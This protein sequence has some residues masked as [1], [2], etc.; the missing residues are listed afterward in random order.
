MQKIQKLKNIIKISNAY[1]IAFWMDE[2]VINLAWLEAT[3]W[4]E[5]DNDIWDLIKELINNN[6]KVELTTNWSTLWKFSKNLIKSGLSKCRISI[7]SFDRNIYKNI[8]GRD[9]LNWVIEGIKDFRE[10]NV[11]III[12]RPLLKGFTDDIPVC[13][14][15]IQKEN[16]TLKLYD[17]WWTKRID[18]IYNNYYIHRSEIIDKYLK[19]KL[20]FVEEKI[21]NFNRNRILYNLVGGGIVD[22][23]VFDN[24]KHDQSNNC[25]TCIFN[26]KCKETFASYIN[27]FSDWY[28]KFCNLRE[29]IFLDLNPFLENNVNE[30][31]LGEFLKINLNNILWSNSQEKIKDI[32]LCFYI[33]NICNH[34]CSFPDIKKDINSLWCLSSV[35]NNKELWY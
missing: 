17:L 27:I 9:G 6:F 26:E 18:N 7:P 23:K 13:L 24:E 10:S 11:K 32:D 31:E 19:N 5:N 16:L 2:L 35:R 28:L 3:L 34:K 30:K 8:T 20:E 21:I 22:I 1:K 29:D 12:N 25:K 14:D 15:F 4:K 33:N